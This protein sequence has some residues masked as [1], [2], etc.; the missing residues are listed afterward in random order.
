MLPNFQRLEDRVCADEGFCP[1][2]YLDSVGIPTIGYGTTCIMGE[3]VTMLNEP[4][5]QQEAK[6]L[7]R[8]D[9]YVALMDAQ[10]IFT[11]LELM[12][13]VRQEVLVNMAYNMGRTRLLGFQKLIAAAAVLDYKTM[14]EEMRDSVWFTQVR[15]RAERLHKAMLTG[16]W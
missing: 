5:T 14:A 7:L 12:N 9:L 13:D 15:R 8:A 16:V 1:T 11:T 2:P 6:Q 4:V 10:L 3:D